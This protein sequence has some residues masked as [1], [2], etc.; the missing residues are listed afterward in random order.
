MKIN[1][2]SRRQFALA[3]FTTAGAFYAAAGWAGLANVS[4]AETL[5]VSS[6]ASRVYQLTPVDP[7]VKQV[8]V[9]AMAVDPAGEF[10]AASGDD[11]V[12]R[13]LSAA[14]LKTVRTLGKGSRSNDA[15]R[16][17]HFDWIRTLTFDDRGTRLASAGN[18]GQLILWDRRNDF[19]V[20]QKI[21]S[22]PA[23][24]CLRFSP[25]GKQIAAVGF[26]PRIFLI[27]GASSTTSSLQ[28]DCIDLRCCEYSGDG[29]MIAVAG[30]DG[31]LHLFDPA[32]GA[33]IHEQ[34][35]H[36]GRVRDMAF[37][38][39]S[40][41][42]VSVAE[43][44]EV[45]RYDVE[46]RQILS[47]RKIT[48]GRLF[49]VAI[50]N[51]RT[52]AAAGSDDEIY[53]VSVDDDDRGLSMAGTLRGHVGS[54]AELVVSGDYLISGGFDATIR[55]W[56]LPSLQSAPSKIALKEPPPGETRIGADPT[57]S[58]AR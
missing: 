28:C 7:H 49:T 21:D 56:E 20:M 58:Q 54:V 23:L 53:L 55:R 16:P 8:V 35:I 25:S 45:V 17:G 12:I 36:Q 31:R 18:D 2:M 15:S 38:A 27:G 57:A 19:Q 48:S 4:A 47:R 6:A 32:N 26:D 52:I 42:L 46:S 14:T 39:E 34:A 51:S 44:G 24:A 10:L 40:A 22:A 1:H 30:R 37:V 3:G 29:K 41:V 33:L 50:I 9:T 13:I 5:A 11:H 43:D